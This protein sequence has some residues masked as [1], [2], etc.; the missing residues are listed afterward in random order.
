MK[1]LLT[2]LVAGLVVVGSLSANSANEKLFSAVKSGDH[3]AIRAALKAGADIDGV[4]ETGRSAL[5]FAIREG[6]IKTVRL[7]LRRGPNLEQVYHLP[8]TAKL[9]P[10]ILTI[11]VL[12]GA[13]LE[14]IKLLIRSGAPVERLE[15]KSQ[16]SPLLAA[17]HNDRLDIAKLLIKHGADV[18]EHIQTAYFNYNALYYIIL[19]KSEADDIESIRLLREK[20]FEIE[21]DN[22]YIES[23]QAVNKSE[24]VEELNRIINEL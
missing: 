7:I 23:A 12:M 17:F 18:N 21:K 5:V 9:K 15:S 22:Q 3:R 20:G 19:S 6:D 10:S 1:K 13:E 2:I 14:L 4:D 8:R 16:T 24:L 11:A